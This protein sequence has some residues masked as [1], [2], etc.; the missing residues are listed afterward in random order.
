MIVSSAG[1]VKGI[2]GDRFGV[3][4]EQFTD[5]VPSYSLPISIKHAPAGTRSYALVLL[6]HDAIPVASFSWIHWVVANLGRTELNE[7]ESI[8]ALDFV[9]GTNSWSSK[10]LPKP[11]S[12][13]RAASYGGMVPPDKPHVYTWKVYALD[14]K[15]DLKNG[16]YL[17]ELFEAMEGHI[18]DE[19]TLRG[20]YYN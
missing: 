6:D 4:G 13:M 10:L 19:A 11:M 18:L 12:K 5:G 16:F 2:I 9:Q 1:I 15:L 17:N 3:R 7:N 14:T 8:E 20:T